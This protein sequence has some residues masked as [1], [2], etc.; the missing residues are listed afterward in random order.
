M[1]SLD[2]Q[3]W[4]LRSLWIAFCAIWIIGALRADRTVKR[5]PGARYWPHLALMGFG[6]ALMLNIFARVSFL[7]QQLWPSSMLFAPGLLLT[8]FGLGLA[9]WARVHLGKYWSAAIGSKVE[10][11]LIESGPYARLR[12]PIYSGVSLAVIGTAI[13]DGN[14]HSLLGAAILV[15]ALVAKAR[16]EETWLI[17]EFGGSY[18]DYRRRSWALLPF[19]Y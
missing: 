7:Q 11:R 16:I 10:H 8:V 5:P 12:H 13:A 2:V 19:I 6:I 1:I 3:V 17:Q 4:L 9:V 15:T 14:V 18:G